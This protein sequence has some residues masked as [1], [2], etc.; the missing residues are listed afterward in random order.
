MRIYIVQTP[1]YR[2]VR[3][4]GWRSTERVGA[5]A[6]YSGGWY[7][8]TTWYGT[9]HAGPYGILTLGQNAMIAAMIVYA[10]LG[11]AVTLFGR[12]GFHITG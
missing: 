7:A 5:L 4:P 12:I 3:L 10:I 8:L 6:T 2:S 1:T 11:I 9:M